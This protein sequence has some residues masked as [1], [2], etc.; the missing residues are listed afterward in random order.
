MTFPREGNL[1]Q[2]IFLPQKRLWGGF[3]PET[4]IQYHPDPPT[5]AFLKKS[6]E[7]HQKSKG[8]SL[9]EPLKSLEKKGKTVK[10]ARELGK[11][12]KSKEIEKARVGGSGQG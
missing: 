8:Y 10:K 3:S 1:P 5:L 4:G 2:A 11:Q 12:Q 6:K 7:T 9:R